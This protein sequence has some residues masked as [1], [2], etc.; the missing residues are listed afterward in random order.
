MK[1]IITRIHERR[2]RLR[3]NIKQTI[4]LV[5]THIKEKEKCQYCTFPLIKNHICL[6]ECTV[7]KCNKKIL[8][9]HKVKEH[10]K[11]NHQNEIFCKFC[12]GHMFNS[13]AHYDI[14]DLIYT[15]CN[16]CSFKGKQKRVINHMK[17]DCFKRDVSCTG[18][19]KIF[20]VKSMMYNSDDKSSR[21]RC[22]D[23]LWCEECFKNSWECQLC[24]HRIKNETDCY[25]H[26]KQC[27][28][29][30]ICIGCCNYIKNY[31]RC[32]KCNP[33]YCACGRLIL[34]EFHS[35]NKM[36]K[37]YFMMKYPSNLTDL[38]FNIFKE[39]GVLAIMLS[40][41][42]W[43][44][45]KRCHFL[46]HCN[47]CDQYFQAF[48][49]SIHDHL[50]ICSSYCR[51]CKSYV[52]NGNM[53]VHKEY[54]S[55]FIKC[56]NCLVDIKRFELIQHQKYECSKRLIICAR[57]SSEYAFDYMSIHQDEYCPETY[58][59]L[60]CKI[61]QETNLLQY[62]KEYVKIPFKCIKSDDETITNYELNPF[63]GKNKTVKRK[64]NGTN[65]NCT[66]F[67]FQLFGNFLDNFF[68]Y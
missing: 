67:T 18:C 60:D 11:E 8:E 54:C 10:F 27:S 63:I 22:Q 57:C 28:S 7:E 38:L 26:L 43:E 61:C 44:D 42:D 5:P 21:L 6:Y 35:T 30:D 50:K 33:K 13:I 2:E 19:L 32:T 16:K 1:A 4:D 24:Y 52:S 25:E 47:Y 58:V 40:Y 37:G 55:S 39:W 20:N 46:R 36:K 23:T 62:S 3:S 45:D 59:L 29:A 49:Y 56:E 51:D 65:H 64:E 48:A 53:D 14:C 9:L 66:K 31:E 12:I 34:G 68:V 15:H 17:Y 41:S